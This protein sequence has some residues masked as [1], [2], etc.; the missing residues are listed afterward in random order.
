MPSLSKH[1][2]LAYR[3]RGLRQAQAER[4]GDV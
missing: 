4:C 1:R 3:Q 2:P